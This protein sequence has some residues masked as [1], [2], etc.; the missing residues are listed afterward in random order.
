MIRIILLKSNIAVKQIEQSEEIGEQ[1]VKKIVRIIIFKNISFE[2][3]EQ[4]EENEERNMIRIILLKIN[5][6]CCQA[7]STI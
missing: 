1:N 6:I 3:R 7:K 5:I 2:Q 4:C